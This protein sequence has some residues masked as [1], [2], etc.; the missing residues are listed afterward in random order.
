MVSQKQGMPT[1]FET[2]TRRYSLLSL[3]TNF[4]FTQP[5]ACSLHACLIWIGSLES[6][7]SA[8]FVWYM[9]G[10]SE[11]CGGGPFCCVLEGNCEQGPVSFV[12]SNVVVWVLV[13]GLD[14]GKWRV[15]YPIGKSFDL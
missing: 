6:L 15:E 13:G 3:A 8:L 11:W 5:H 9:R 14:W 10:S 12:A 4:C 7:P 2:L 1:I